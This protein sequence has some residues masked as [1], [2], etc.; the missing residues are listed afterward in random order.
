MRHAWTKLGV[1][2]SLQT[3]PDCEE[4]VRYL[5]GHGPYVDRVAHP[6]PVLVLVDLKMPRMSGLEL[7]QWIRSQPALDELPIII[8]S[9]SLRPS[10]KEQAMAFGT[11]DYFVKPGKLQNLMIMVKTVNARL[12]GRG[13]DAAH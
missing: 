9:S 2:H 5:S 13:D 11:D 12:N 1:N 10:D 6:A 3:V 7:L 8:L 4:A